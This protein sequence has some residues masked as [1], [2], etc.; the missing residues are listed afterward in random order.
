MLL[1]LNNAEIKIPRRI[2]QRGYESLD[3]LIEEIVTDLRL[4]LINQLPHII[5]TSLGPMHEVT[6]FCMSNS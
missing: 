2:Y 5:A 1:Q 6:Q 4:V 3:R